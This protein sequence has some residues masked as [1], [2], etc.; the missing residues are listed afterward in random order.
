MLLD[1]LDLILSQLLFKLKTVNNNRNTILIQTYLS[2]LYNLLLKIFI[3]IISFINS[4]SIIPVFINKNLFIKK[5]NIITKRLLILKSLRLTNRLLSN[6]ITYYFIIKIIISHYIEFILFYII[7]LLLLILIIFKILQLKKHNLK[8]DFPVLELK[9]N[10][11][12]YIYNNL[13]QYIFDYN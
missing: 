5:Y 6:F 1:Q 12:Y 7:K 9:F 11:N 4:G 13:L 2:L 3:K 10:S 8:L